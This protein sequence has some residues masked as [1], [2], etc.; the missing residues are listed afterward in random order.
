MFLGLFPVSGSTVTDSIA[1]SHLTVAPP[2]RTLTVDGR[3]SASGV[4][5]LDAET[6]QRLFAR[7]AR[8]QRPM[9]SLTK[10]MTALLIVENHDMSETVTIPKIAEETAGSR[11]YLSAGKRYT[12]G[13]LLSA[14]LINSANDAAVTLAVYHSGS[15]SAFD[16]A[17]NKRALELG[18]R[19]TSFTNPIGLDGPA[20]WSTP[21]DI[22][23]LTNF[24]LGKEEISKRMGMGGA[25]IASTDGTETLRLYHTHNLL[26]V[27][28]LSPESPVV[29][30]GKTGTTSEAG[31]CLVSVV[32]EAGKKFVVVLLDS[33]QRYKD[34]DMILSSIQSAYGIPSVA[35]EAN[36]EPPLA[37]K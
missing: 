27:H 7:D 12:V 8:V 17:M 2:A 18:L 33:H 36:V 29:I 16:A 10:L 21:Q 26:H 19:E 30:G 28:P 24:V 31:E 34:M 23:W 32:R 5:V 1:L 35:E 3:L 13:S 15:L 25:R 22:A 14:L 20:H 6:G 37:A 9:A 11:V 4:Y